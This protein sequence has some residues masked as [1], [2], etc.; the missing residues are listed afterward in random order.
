MITGMLEEASPRVAVASLDNSRLRYSVPADGS[1]KPD[2]GGANGHEPP[3]GAL[4]TEHPTQPGVEDPELLRG[5]WPL[6]VI[7]ETWP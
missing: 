7:D 2:D 1:G 3:I 6:T 5:H 4:G